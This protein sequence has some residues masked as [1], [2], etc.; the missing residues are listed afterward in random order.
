MR[1][2]KV[3]TLAFVGIVL[4][5]CQAPKTEKK[6]NIVCTTSMI[7]DMVNNLVGD[8]IE[9]VS[10]MGAGVDPHLYKPTSKD[11][12]T[13]KD[14]GIILFNG[15]HLEG[16]TQEALEKL[17]R[18]KAVYAVADGIPESA[19]RATSEFDGKY[20]PHIW[21]D[22]DNWIFCTKYV[23]KQLQKEFP[24][25]TEMIKERELS[26]L[27]ELKETDSLVQD[28]INQISFES[29]YL[30]TAHDAFSY[31]GMGYGIKVKALQ[32]LSTLSEVGI[33]DVMDLSE[34]LQTNKINAIFGESIVSDRTIR[35][36]IE[37]CEENGHQVRIGG[38]LF[39]DAMG[40]EGTPGGTY[41]GMLLHNAKTISENL[42]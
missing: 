34:F 10:L 32:G 9:V 4:V 22:I 39:S 12:G 3:L 26:Y 27:M 25:Y 29:R 33:K 37:T 41:I 38:S 8:S 16:K 11:L 35:K 7:G 6:K 31:F 36:V 17:G 20:D 42:K 13:L 5:A 40:E 14:A 18:K 19:L 21:L 2:L 30:V 15:L 24:K 23:A 1:K 28:Y